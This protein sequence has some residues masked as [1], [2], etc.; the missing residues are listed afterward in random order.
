MPHS[1]YFGPGLFASLQVAAARPSV[2][3][4]EYNFVKPDAWLAD[5]DGLRTGHHFA[6]PQTPGI[7]FTPDPD[8]LRRYRRA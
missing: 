8:V 5:V 7:G 4:L 2:E 3:A 1:P 6:V